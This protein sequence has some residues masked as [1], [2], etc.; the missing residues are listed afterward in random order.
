MNNSAFPTP[1]EINTS[2]CAS[3]WLSDNKTKIIKME[4]SKQIRKED[5]IQ[6]ITLLAFV[7]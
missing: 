4:F 1:M 6:Y 3:I 2:H 7:N 5:V